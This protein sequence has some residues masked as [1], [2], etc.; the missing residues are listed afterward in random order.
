MCII[1]IFLYFYKEDD[2]DTN[3]AIFTLRYE[4]LQLQVVLSVLLCRVLSAAY[5]YIMPLCTCFFT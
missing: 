3:V 1:F 4:F 5:Q 2:G